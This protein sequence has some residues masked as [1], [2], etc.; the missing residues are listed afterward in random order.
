L[1]FVTCAAWVLKIKTSQGTIVLEDL[2]DDAIVRIDGN[3]VTITKPRG[4]P[5]RIGASAGEHSVVIMRGD[6]VVYRDTVT[7]ESGQASGII[8]LAPTPTIAP[9]SLSHQGHPSDLSAASHPADRDSVAPAGT[10]ATESKGLSPVPPGWVSL[11]NGRDLTGWRTASPDPRANWRVVNGRLV[12][13]GSQPSHLYTERANFQDFHLVVEACVNN[14]GQGGICFRSSFGPASPT[15]PASRI[16]TQPAGYVA[17]INRLFGDRRRTGALGSD[18]F[19]EL[20]T[21][22]DGPA[23]QIAPGQWFTLQVIAQRN[24]I[25]IIVDGKVTAYHASADQPYTGGHIAL[26]QADGR[27]IMEFRSIEIKELNSQVREDA[28]EWRRFI[29]HTSRV[30]R[31]ALAPDERT[32]L[33]GGAGWESAVNKDGSKICKYLGDNVLRLWDTDT[34]LAKFTMGEDPYQVASIALSSD[35]RYAASCTDH[36]RDEQLPP[37]Q[38]PSRAVSVWNLQTGRRAHILREPEQPDPGGAPPHHNYAPGHVTELA[39]SPDDRRVLAARS[40]GIVVVWD[41]DT[42]QVRP[43]IA[44]KGDRFRDR[45]FPRAAFVDDSRRLVT[46][47]QGGLVE[48]WSLQTGERVQAM[49]GQIGEVRGVAA[50]DGGRF[51]LAGGSDCIVHFWDGETGAEIKSFRGDDKELRCVALAPDGRRALSAGIDAVIRVW[52]PKSGTEIGQL[53]GHT[54]GINAVAFSPDGRL[55]V[56]GSDDGTVRVWDLP[57]LDESAKHTR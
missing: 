39:I 50:S 31:V 5:A 12:C 4:E 32:V 46:G 1:L 36:A 27:T 53:V 49:A 28:R 6:R 8:V 18:D 16:R 44:L 40:N 19:S 55:A 3:L 33:S 10:P 11:F 17:L 48:L 26:Q 47:S 51:I 34:G 54:M 38:R 2:P 13:S 52:D 14:G 43:A 15:A 35:G 21:A 29:G 37:D 9:G 20:I 24:I 42:E 41:L 30:S 56:S 57:D 7:L 25:T 45:E 22:L 23:V